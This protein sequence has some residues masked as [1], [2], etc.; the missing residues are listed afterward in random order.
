MKIQAP[1]TVNAL[2]IILATV[3][4]GQRGWG[5]EMPTQNSVEGSP[6]CQRAYLQK[7][8]NILSLPSAIS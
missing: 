7:G 3:S 2:R 8:Q 6:S 5:R 4:I 1:V